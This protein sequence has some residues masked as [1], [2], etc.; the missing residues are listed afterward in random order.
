V[1]GLL[2]AVWRPR[3][4]VLGALPVDIVAVD[5]DAAFVTLETARRL[6]ISAD[7][8]A[9]LELARSRGLGLATLDLR[10]TTACRTVGVP[11]IAEAGIRPRRPCAGHRAPGSSRTPQEPAWAMLCAATWHAAGGTAPDIAQ[12]DRWWG[13]RRATLIRT[14]AAVHSIA[15]GDI[16]WESLAAWSPGVRLLAEPPDIGTGD[17]MRRDRAWPGESGPRNRPTR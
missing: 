16:W 2:T 1:I 8:P 4:P 11:L 5:L 13:S 6:G 15:L 17:A 10:L 14:P 3:G 9:Y 12:P 7:D